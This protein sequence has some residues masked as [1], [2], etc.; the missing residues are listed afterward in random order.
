MTEETRYC[1]EHMEAVAA[2]LDKMAAKLR[3][4]QSDDLYH[5]DGEID[6][7]EKVYAV[8]L[9]GLDRTREMLLAIAADNK[10]RRL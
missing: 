8:L 3:S 4:Y 9:D 1:L 7:P 6:V 5:H 10:V 2:W